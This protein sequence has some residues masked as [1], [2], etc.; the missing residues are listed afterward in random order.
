MPMLCINSS[1]KSQCWTGKK[2]KSTLWVV[3][4]LIFMIIVFQVVIQKHQQEQAIRTRELRKLKNTA[5]LL[6]ESVCL[7][8][9]THLHTCLQQQILGALSIE[10]KTNVSS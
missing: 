9:S 5:A 3:A 2:I 4:A 1:S 6:G 7:P 8:L 10:R